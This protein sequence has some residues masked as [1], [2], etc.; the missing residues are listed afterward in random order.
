MTVPGF[1]A[2]IPRRP[3]IPPDTEDRKRLRTV[4]PRLTRRAAADTGAGKG[5]ITAIATATGGAGQAEAVP[6]VTDGSGAGADGA[7]GLAV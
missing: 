3:H 4:I 5:T 7:G 6:Q 2:I 1:D